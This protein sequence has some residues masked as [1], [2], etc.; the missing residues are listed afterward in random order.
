MRIN[1]KETILGFPILEIRRLLRHGHTGVSVQ[2]ATSMLS[3]PEDKA[4]QLLEG[5]FEQG[6]VEPAK[7]G[8]RPWWQNTI[9]GQ[10]LAMAKAGGSPSSR[11][12]ADR[13]FAEFMERVKKVNED[14]YYL[15]K[16]TKVVL[17]GSYLTDAP[18]VNDIDVAVD[19]VLKEEDPQRCYQL[20]D[21]RIREAAEQGRE[22]SS[23]TDLYGWPE[24][25]VQLF[26][27]S[28]SRILSLHL[29]DDP[30]LRQVESKVVYPAEGK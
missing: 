10:A 7:L 12:T 17:F 22:F 27:K 16:V 30:V 8:G 9:K 2:M 29:A 24:R 25:E 1:P 21:A 20:M 6:Y 13:I 19:L 14:P 23:I 4:K 26:L 28:R 11:R 15:Y 5:L 3:I 18:Q